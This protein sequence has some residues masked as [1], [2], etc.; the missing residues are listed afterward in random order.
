MSRAQE[1]LSP[2]ACP[3]APQAPWGHSDHPVP[4]PVPAQVTCEYG[5]VHVMSESG[6]PR[7]KDYCILYNPQWA[8]LPHDLGKAVRLPHPARGCGE[9]LVPGS[10][11]PAVPYRGAA[12]H[13]PVCEHRRVA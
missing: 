3:K 1:R 4:R 6:V 13:L 5:M 12:P 10:V 11:H 8:H 7:G 9:G 2:D